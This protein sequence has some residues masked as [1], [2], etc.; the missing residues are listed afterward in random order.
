MGRSRD[1]P[2]TS[3]A[4]TAKK[5]KHAHMDR[6]IISVPLPITFRTT[7]ARTDERTESR[8]NQ[9][10]SLKEPI[11]LPFSSQRTCTP[12]DEKSD[13]STRTSLPE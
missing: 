7:G 10:Q 9:K 11:L 6:H 2:R 8:A 4:S 1:P 5:K 3:T 13:R 12:E